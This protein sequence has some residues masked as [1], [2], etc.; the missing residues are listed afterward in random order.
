MPGATDPRVRETAD[1][2]HTLPSVRR[3][4]TQA[5]RNG[6]VG[7]YSTLRNRYQ[8]LIDTGVEIPL[9]QGYNQVS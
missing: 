6:A 3:W 5:F 8:D 4:Q 9:F 2:E 7:G 1:S